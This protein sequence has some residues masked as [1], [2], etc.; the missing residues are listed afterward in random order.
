MRNIDQPNATCIKDALADMD[1]FH[2][3]VSELGVSAAIDFGTLGSGFTTELE[4]V[5]LIALPSGNGRSVLRKFGK[6]LLFL[7]PSCIN[8]VNNII[9]AISGCQYNLPAISDFCKYR[10]ALTLIKGV[11]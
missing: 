4:E 8:R 3:Q 6:S 2:K 10:T 11:C 5:N 7:F 1:M 9:P